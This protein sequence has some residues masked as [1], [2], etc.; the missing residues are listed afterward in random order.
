NFS[1]W[2]DDPGAGPSRQYN[3]QRSGILLGI[4][5]SGGPTPTPR[6]P[7][8]SPTRGPTP[9][10]RP[11]SS[12]R[13]PTP[14]P[15]PSPGPTVGPS[16][17]PT[18]S[19][20]SPNIRIWGLIDESY[21]GGKRP[22]P[23][24]R[25]RIVRR[26]GL[27]GLG[28]FFGR[29]HGDEIPPFN[30]TDPNFNGVSGNDGKY[31][32]RAWIDPNETPL[33]VNIVAS[34]GQFEEKSE[35][36]EIPNL[37]PRQKP[38]RSPITGAIIGYEDIPST[39]EQNKNY[40]LDPTGRARKSTP[41]REKIRGEFYTH[42]GWGGLLWAVATF[43]V[44]L[45]FYNDIIGRILTFFG[46]DD[47]FLLNS[48]LV[49][50][51]IPLAIA[52]FVY[53]AYRA[54]GS[55]KVIKYVLPVAGVYFLIFYVIDLHTIGDLINFDWYLDKLDLLRWLG[56]SQDTIDGM[57]DGVRNTLSFLQFKGAEP[58]KPEAKK[59]G[60]FEAMQFKFGSGQNDYL[61]P[62]LF[63][64]MDYTLPL[65]VTNPN[66]F[67]TNLVGKSFLIDEIFLKNGS[68]LIMCGSTTAT[69][70]D[71][72]GN[73]ISV[74]K[75]KIELG[76]VNP[77][78]EKVIVI[79]FMNKTNC[80]DVVADAR[81]YDAAEKEAANPM[82]PVKV[83][84]FMSEEDA[85]NE[86]KEELTKDPPVE[87]DQACVNVLNDF[88][89][90]YQIPESA[91]SKDVSA[92]F[93][94]SDS[95]CE[96]KINRYFNIMDELCF[97][98]NNQAKASLRSNFGFS[99]QGKGE[100]IL[101]KSDADRKLAPKPEITSS[102][103]PLT[104]TTYFISDIHV[105]DKTET[106]RMFV[107]IANDGDG[108]A[109]I[110]D[111]RKTATPSGVTIGA[112]VP[113]PN[114]A[115]NTKIP[116]NKDGITVSC[117]VAVTADA[118]GSITGSYLTIPVIVDIDYTY[119]QTHSTTINVKKETIPDGVTDNDQ[120]RELNRQFKP[121]PY[122]CPTKNVNDTNDEFDTVPLKIYG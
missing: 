103:G 99:V 24:A 70:K 8:P 42:F 73:P 66:K 40:A 11:T 71:A 4:Y 23:G 28:R 102:A 59:I 107:Q 19:P 12:P 109:Q 75:G 36:I 35:M 64:R 76:D 39:H 93:V 5:R 72:D 104:V 65:T 25:V 45:W 106:T 3:V 62:T 86:C 84:I 38:I 30:P 55:W 81:G 20:Q 27:G 96:C 61:L 90:R 108:T 118:I 58:T 68:T 92:K 37:R 63:A 41:A 77:E 95:A 114:K 115:Q 97:I 43:A 18:I 100:M 16:P 111:L 52:L 105:P 80:I 69:G 121:L 10:S 101:V 88:Y 15:N 57:K 29:P 87:K 122:Y 89:T 94:K 14:G 117:P 50:I 54:G 48:P 110:E 7:T 53:F 85:E 44:L 13:P 82:F 60:G 74:L 98:D 91:S 67:D 119:Q 83:R 79:D 116:V 47:F 113:T 49:R 17:S 56:I 1:N 34:R 46:L 26:G 9:T 112:C 22:L 33:I 51:G 120:I 31:D 6:P 2:Q 32:Y 78:E 21:P